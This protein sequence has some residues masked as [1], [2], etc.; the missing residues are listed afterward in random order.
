MADGAAR[1]VGSMPRARIRS[2]LYRFFRLLADISRHPWAYLTHRSKFRVIAGPGLLGYAGGVFNPGAVRMDDG[3][4]I[5]LA[6]AQV[7]HWLYADADNYMRGAPVVVRLEPGLRL[8]SAEVVSRLE[9]FPPDGDVEIED[10]RMFRFN[11]QLWVNHSLIEVS[12]TEGTTGYRGSRVGLSRLEPEAKALTFL[13]HPQID[14]DMQRREK[15][16]VFVELRGELYLFYSFLPYRV[17]RL[18]DRQRLMF[19]TVVDSAMDIDL[20]TLGGFAAPVSYSTNPIAYDE[21]RLLVLV[22]QSVRRPQG[23]CYYHWG[24]LLARDTLLPVRITSRAIVAGIGARGVMR[25][26]LYVSSVARMGDSFVL[27]NGEGDTFVTRTRLS[28]AQLDRSW[29]DLPK[30]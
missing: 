28:R 15:N 19:S 8:E 6:K 4:L 10:F 17:L 23:R 1:S 7:E 20:T 11:G 22:H 5:L 30:R 24:V 9:R 13:G 21:D 12:R 26:V 14:F 16:W 27:F 29:F 2:R 3:R 18:V 25:G